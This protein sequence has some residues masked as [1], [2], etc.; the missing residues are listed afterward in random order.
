MLAPRENKV[1]L[2]SIDAN[3][4]LFLVF[5]CLFT[6][7]IYWIKQKKMSVLDPLHQL[8]G[9]SF[10]CGSRNVMW[11]K[12]RKNRKQLSTIKGLITTSL[13]NSDHFC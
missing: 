6:H 8:D 12:Q 13:L 2:H 10:L 1:G 3:N 11:I 9:G 4:E 7:A 5:T